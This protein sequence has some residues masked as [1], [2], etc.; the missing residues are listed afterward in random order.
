VIAENIAAALG[1]GEAEPIEVPASGGVRVARRSL[2][3]AEGD[4]AT[5]PA[6]TGLSYS[7]KGVVHLGGSSLFAELA[8]ARLFRLA[9][10]SAHWRDGYRGGWVADSD[11]VHRRKKELPPS[12][13]RSLVEQIAATRGGRLGGC[14]DVVASAGDMVAFAECKRLRRDPLNENQ[15]R[16]LR[17]CLDINVAL[18][19]F[20]VVEWDFESGTRPPSHAGV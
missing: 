13:A 4:S 16:W 15:G 8:V 5:L 14:W 7:R 6:D 3:F 9:G 19:A 17:A 1:G 12:A 2:V 11:P 18:E 10:W 20:V